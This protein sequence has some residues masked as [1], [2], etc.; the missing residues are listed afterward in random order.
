MTGIV[1]VSL[2]GLKEVSTAQSRGMNQRTAI[3]MSNMKA[4]TREME[5]RFPGVFGLD[6]DMLDARLLI[7]LCLPTIKDNKL[8]DSDDEHNQEEEV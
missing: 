2:S 3:I 8:N 6:V 1:V 4:S 7:A 5:R